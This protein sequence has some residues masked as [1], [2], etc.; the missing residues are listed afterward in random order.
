MLPDYSHIPLSREDLCPRSIKKFS[1]WRRLHEVN[2]PFLPLAETVRIVFV[3][4]FTEDGRSDAGRAVTPVLNP[5]FANKNTDTFF[6]G[7]LGNTDSR[8]F[9]Q[10]SPSHR[11]VPPWRLLGEV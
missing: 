11:L 4:R 6:P 9:Y 2:S 1:K 5:A 7:A 3:R 10:Y 8:T